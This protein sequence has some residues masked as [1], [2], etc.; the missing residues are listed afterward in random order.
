M[1]VGRR[2][3]RKLGQ[4]FLVDEG[5]ADRIVEESG[6]KEGDRV[7]E[8]GPGR[9]VLTRR[10]I[11][12][13][14]FVR[15]VELDRHLHAQLKE[16]LDKPGVC[17]IEWGNALKFDFDSIEAPFDIVSN[18]PYSVSVALIKMFFDHIGKIKSMTLM[19]QSEVAKRLTAKAGDSAYGSLSVYTSYHCKTERLFTVQP[20]AFSP[21]PKVESAV[22]GLKPLPDGEEPPVNAPDKEAFF[23][24]VAASFV[25]RRKTIKNNLRDLWPDIGSFEKS[26]LTTGVEGSERP[27]EISLDR[28]AA[29]FNEWEKNS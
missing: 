15:A 10:L 7:L 29:L 9:G 1:A 8:V 12:K 28:F 5:I 14:A 21:R 25:H 19:V 22:I 11:D 20:K 2:K 24:F 27:Q 23:K 6:V 16:K 17:E 26:L 18:L 4:H 13:G 3:R